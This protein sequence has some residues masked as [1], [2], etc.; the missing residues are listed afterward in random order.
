MPQ[1]FI[2]AEPDSILT[3]AQREF[4]RPWLNQEE[5][6]SRGAYFIPEYSPRKIGEDIAYFTQ[7][8]R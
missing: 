6:R 1:L 5:V 2:D 4:C 8:R 7:Q 3:G